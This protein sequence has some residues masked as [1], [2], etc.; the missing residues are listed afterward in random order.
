MT[1][2]RDCV[3]IAECLDDGAS[4][5]EKELLSGC[6]HVYTHFEHPDFL[7]MLRALSDYHH[8]VESRLMP[9]AAMWMEEHKDEFKHNLSQKER[10]DVGATI[11]AAY[12]VVAETEWW[13]K[14]KQNGSDIYKND[15]FKSFT[16][17]PIWQNITKEF[18]DKEQAVKSK[19]K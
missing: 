16:P 1:I 10:D 18:F 15:L 5:T 11:E 7:R 13:K 3:F 17:N 14:I 8:W 2:K 12:K 19:F 4:Y 9:I 6:S